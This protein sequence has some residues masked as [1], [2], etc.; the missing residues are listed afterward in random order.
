MLDHF[1]GQRLSTKRCERSHP[2][3]R[4][5]ESA[6]LAPRPEWVRA[7]TQNRHVAR[8]IAEDILSRGE[9][10]TAIFAASDLQALG[11]LEAARRLNIDV[12]GEL[13]VVGFDDVEI[14]SYANLTTVRQPLF[15]SGKFGTELLLQALAGEELP[16]RMQ[17]LPL[18][19]IARGTTAPPRD[20]S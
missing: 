20:R 7:G 14:A 2:H 17:S 11:V 8:S 5:L 13:S 6:G 18:E 12:P 4:A 3:E 9:R 15:E 1:L 10:P 19:L 16:T